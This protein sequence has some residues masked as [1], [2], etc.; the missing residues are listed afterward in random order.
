MHIVNV[1]KA[2]RARGVAPNSEDLID[3]IFDGMAIMGR[4]P[5]YRGCL[6]CHRVGHKIRD[7][8]RKGARKFNQNERK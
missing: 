5:P 6:Y 8:D 2:L 1:Q 7:C 3:K 4:T